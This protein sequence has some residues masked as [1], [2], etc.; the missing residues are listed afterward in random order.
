MRKHGAEVEK[1]KYDLRLF[2]VCLQIW[3][4]SFTTFE[5]CIVNYDLVVKDLDNVNF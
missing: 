2:N 3:E 5:K 1:Y 4:N